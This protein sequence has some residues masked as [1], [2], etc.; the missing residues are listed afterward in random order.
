[1]FEPRSNTS[2]RKIF[3]A[4]FAKALALADRV[5]LAPLNQ[6]EKVPDQERM[7]VE[8]VAEDINRLS[9]EHQARVIPRTDEIA[10][11]IAQR[12]EA[13]DIVLVM[14]NGAFDGLP[15][16]ILRALQS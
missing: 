13:G 6:P 3:E 9:A 5:V 8:K 16:K 4:E 1:V 2:R 12:A 7:S 14:S 11:H 10:A 15:D